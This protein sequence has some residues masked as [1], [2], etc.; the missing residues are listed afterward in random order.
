MAKEIS[1]DFG[2]VKEHEV[3]KGFYYPPFKTQPQIVV[4]ELGE[5]MDAVRLL[6]RTV[7][8][9]TKG[10]V[11]TFV[12][13]DRGN[14]NLPIHRLV[15]FTFIDR[16]SRHLDKPFHELQVNHIDGNKDNNTKPNLEWV[17]GFENMHHA[18]ETGLFSNGKA[19]LVKDTITGEV[20]VVKSV[21]ECSR[22]F[23]IS[24]GSMRG[25]LNSAV[26]GRISVD[27]KLFKLDDGKPWPELLSLLSGMEGFIELRDIVAHNVETKVTYLTNT[28]A[29]A[30]DYIGVD[31]VRMKNHRRRKGIYVPCDG[32]IL[33]SLDQFQEFMK[34]YEN[35]VI[36]S[37]LAAISNRQTQLRNQE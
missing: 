7:N 31:L 12:K 21:S 3:L 16:P 32:W 24:F 11:T 18:R 4:N 2:L 19:V 35:G 8:K 20:E 14:L 33:C 22:K 10:Y 26:A 13:I 25:H 29:A 36:C 37:G 6:K 23:L 27:N 30:C 9:S 1:L 5:V 34:D 15:A 28:L 17:D